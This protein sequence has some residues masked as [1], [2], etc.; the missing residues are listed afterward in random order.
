MHLDDFS[1]VWLTEVL[2]PILEG[3]TIKHDSHGE[4]Y[5]VLFWLIL[6]ES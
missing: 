6:P 4:F 2:M 1:N 3:L 5:K